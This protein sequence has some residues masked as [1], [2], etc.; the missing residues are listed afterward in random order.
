M[1]RSLQK[2]PFV[3]P[4]LIRKTLKKDRPIQTW[5]R[6]CFILPEFIGLIFQVHQGKTFVRFQVTEEMV[7]SKLGEYALTRKANIFK[8]KQ[9]KK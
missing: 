3:S 6:N 4:S 9:K 7:G 1:A 8:K 2:A 5:A